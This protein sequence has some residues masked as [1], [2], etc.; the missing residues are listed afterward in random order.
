MLNPLSVENAR[1]LRAFF[2]QTGYNETTLRKHLGAAELPSAHLR[3][4]A[5]LLDRTSAP[6]PLNT[7]LRWFWLGLPQERDSAAQH[8]PAAELALM[9]QAGLLAAD[10]GMLAPRAMLLHFDG[11]LV[12]SDHP[13]AIEA[14]QAEMV[15]WPNP[16]SKFL[17]RFAVK[18]RSRATLDLGTGSGILSLGAAA[19]SD[20]V[21][22]TDLNQRAVACAQFNARL[23]A[24]ENVEV[25]AG[26]C[27]APVQG[28]TFDLILSNPPFFITPQ[29]DYLFCDNPMELDSLCRRLVK[30][31]PA[32][33]NE[34]GYM[35]MLCEWAQIKDQPW[36]ERVAEWLIDT[37]CDAWV[38][39]GVTQD[40]EEY[41][42]HRIRETSTDTSG[43]NARYAEYMGYYRH[44]GVEAIHSGVLVMRRRSGQNFVRI[45]EVPPTPTGNL[46]EMILSTFAAHDL[47]RENSTD[48]NLLLLAPRLAD[49]ARLEQICRPVNG[50]WQA[51][52][53][54]L[55]LTTGFAFHVA[56]QPL[57]A[58][59]LVAFDGT[60]TVAAAIQQFA[61]K[62]GAPI[63]KVQPECLSMV[64]KLVERGF[65]VGV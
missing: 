27:F 29:A 58:D 45:E 59:F 63:A 55:R 44:R 37:G 56:L 17:A 47:L 46:G 16:T 4:R 33:L 52:K 39:K 38:M 3:N 49:H 31:G 21:V 60:R 53:L 24:V 32:Y 19:Y 20:T 1:T 42:Q 5:R 28:R 30:E 35:Q 57:V 43:D 50:Q 64:R 8:I 9:L 54:N 6:T 34:G 18:R 13:T 48:E 40:P 26:D 22:A 41:A 7:L 51:E 61:A 11:F 15:L 12:A 62:A 65:L 23:N 14:R 2:E 36:E 10:D 25:L